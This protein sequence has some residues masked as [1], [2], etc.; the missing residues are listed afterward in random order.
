MIGQVGF[1]PGTAWGSGMTS[2]L[3]HTL[4]RKASV[5]AGDPDGSNAFDPAAEW[6]GYRS[7]TPSTAWAQHTAACFAPPAEVVINELDFDT[8]GA[9]AAEFIEL[10]DGGAGNTPLDGLAVVLYNGANDTS[11]AAYDLDG[12]RTDAAGYFVLGNPGVTPAPASSSP[13]A[14]CRTAQT[15][16]RSTAWTPAPS[17]AAHQSPP[18]TCWTPW[19]TTRPTR[20]IPASGPAQRGPATGGRGGRGQQRGP[21]GRPL[22]QRRGR[23]CATPT[24]TCP[25]RPRPARPTPARATASASAATRRPWCT[26]SRAA[27]RPAPWWA[28]VRVVEGQVVGDF[29]DPVTGLGGFF[30]QEDAG[31]D[32][33]RLGHVGGHLRLRQRLR[34]GC[35]HEATGCGCGARSASTRG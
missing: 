18:P 31:R 5:S 33:R 12:Y 6:D 29:Q 25:A 13:T 3:D 30:L 34:R 32:G 21:V 28:R 11:Y 22:P 4:R 20:T 15:R 8:P 9:D 19:S 2:T 24:A 35:G 26:P 14:S 1:D 27:A 17:P 7:A 10:Y 16:R 23:R